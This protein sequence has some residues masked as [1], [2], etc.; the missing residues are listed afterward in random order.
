MRLKTLVCA[1]HRVE[2]YESKERQMNEVIARHEQ[3]TVLT[4]L[5]GNVR[6]HS[7][8]CGLWVVVLLFFPALLM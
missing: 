2:D 5:H 4:V 6:S 7:H 1:H 3:L 8:C